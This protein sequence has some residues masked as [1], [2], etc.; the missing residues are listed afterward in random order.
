MIFSEQR[1]SNVGRKES[2]QEGVQTFRVIAGQLA[3]SL[4]DLQKV[5]DDNNA[6]KKVAEAETLVSEAALRLS[7]LEEGL[8]K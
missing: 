5:T 2:F 7:Y 3:D 6:A 1:N 8:K 4:H